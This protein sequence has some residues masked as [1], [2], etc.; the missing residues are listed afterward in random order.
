M[1]ES[2]SPA[3]TTSDQM[4]SSYMTL[5]AENR[6]ESNYARYLRGTEQ[7]IED[8]YTQVCVMS[9]T[10]DIAPTDFKKMERKRLQEAFQK[11]TFKQ[12]QV[13]EHY[14]FLNKN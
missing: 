1:P 4:V 7:I 12:R 10:P 5:I 2:L 8:S 14:Y 3:G 13:I 6:L 11:L 9:Y